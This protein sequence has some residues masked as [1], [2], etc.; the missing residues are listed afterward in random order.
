MKGVVPPRPTSATVEIAWRWFLLAFCV[1]LLAALAMV[2]GDAVRLRPSD[3]LA[4]RSRSLVMMVPAIVGLFRRYQV[5]LEGLLWVAGSA[6]AVLWIVGGA[7]VTARLTGRRLW[8]LAGLRALALAA[9]LAAI[10]SCVAVIAAVGS[11]REPQNISL[12]LVSLFSLVVYACWRWTSLLLGV[13]TYAPDLRQGWTAFV[14]H[15]PALAL[16]AATNSTLKWLS[17]FATTVA[18]MGVLLLLP[19]S[20]PQWPVLALFVV[21]VLAVISV[22]GLFA[23]QLKEQMATECTEGHGRSSSVPSV[24]NDCF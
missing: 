17:M 20:G 13:L 24:A 10:L 5:I 15:G 19:R 9:G 2:A 22:S 16:H 12:G 6:V 11:S 18:A 1:A 21:W 23:A 3:A 14:A 8:F 4:F 7:A